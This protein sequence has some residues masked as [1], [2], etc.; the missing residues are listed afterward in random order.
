VPMVVHCPD[1]IAPGTVVEPIVANIDVAPTL[2]DAAGLDRPAHMDGQSFLPLLRGQTVP[3]R[4]SLLY[5]YYWEYS[6][7]QTPTQFALRGDRYKYVF[8]HGVW[9]IDMLF[10]LQ[11]D[12][13]EARNL[14]DVPEHQD[15][16]R[17]LRQE[18]FTELTRLE[19]MT[20]PL[21]PL[22]GGQQRLRSPAGA[23]AAP[24]PPV[25]TAKPQP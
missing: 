3:W 20:I 13:A 17:R 21:Y 14:I 10:D 23:P 18:L 8:T 16:A 24:F 25:M 12:P 15:L 4:T 1:L 22:R 2:L 5:E 19:G 9:D 7:P 6:F 11:E